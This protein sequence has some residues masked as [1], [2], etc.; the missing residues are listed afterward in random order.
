MVRLK[1]VKRCLD[2]HGET[3][4]NET[5][6]DEADR[7]KTDR[8]KTGRNQ[9]EEYKGKH[10]G[11]K[12]RQMH[13]GFC[14]SHDSGKLVSAV[15]QSGGFHDCGETRRT[16]CTGGGR[17]INSNHDALCNGSHWHRNRLFGGDFPV[18][19]GRKN[20]G[21]EDKISQ[22][23]QKLM[24]EDLTLKAVNDSENGQ[25]LL[26]GIGEQHLEIVAAKLLNRYK[27]EIELMKP[28]V[29][30]KETIQK[31]ADVEYKYKKQSGGHGQ[32]GHVKMTFEPSNDLKTPYTF[33]Q[34]V[35]GGAV[36]KNYFPA[37]E[38]G[39]EE[40]VKSGPLAAYPVVG[41]KAVLYDGSYHPVDSSEMAFKV[42]AMQAFKKGF[43]ETEPVLLEPIASLKVV[44]PEHYTGDV[45]GDLNKRRARVLGMNPVEE[46][47]QEILAEIPYLELDG[48]TTDL[49]SMTGGRGEYSYEFLKYEK[50]PY[51][52]QQKQI[53]ERAKKV[54][55]ME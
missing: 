50:A 31:K 22:A 18:V 40:A 33:E 32:Y 2:I 29:A 41:V 52:I 35:V 7:N 36:P 34:I 42:A 12:S 49:R 1:A 38:K 21:D 48:Y 16:G 3:G 11:G 54:K 28:K 6:R 37:V 23:L 55:E 13:A 39:I 51:E 44:V 24:A 30:F 20:K 8:N 15:L 47:K 53:E 19:W 4:R 25:T 46:E 43:L 26:Y 5:D 45:M 17:W 14:S 10:D 9:T 27:V